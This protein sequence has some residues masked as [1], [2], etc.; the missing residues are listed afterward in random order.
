MKLR[1]WA[2]SAAILSMVCMAGQVQAAE[3]DTAEV[4]A[5]I[6]TAQKRE[7]NLQ[8]VPIVVNVVS[9][10]QLQ[11]AGVRDVKDLQVLTPGLS[12]TSSTGGAQ[13][14]IRIRG[15]GTIGDNPGLESSVGTVI[16]GV[17][18]ARSGVAFG[19]L[20][21]LERIEVLK[22]PQGT[23]FGKNTSAGV[24][25]VI[26]KA[27]E[28]D[29][30]ANAELTYGNHD[31][32]GASA[33]VTGPIGE[34]VAGRL[35][36]ALRKRDGFYDVKN[37]AGP[38]TQ[39]DNDDQDVF[40]VR[41]QLLWLPTDTLT[42]RGMVDY[43]ERNEHCCLNVTTLVGATGAIIDALA[44]DEGTLRPAD[45]FRRL[46]YANRESSQTIKDKG[47]SLQADWEINPDITLTS[48]T[49]WRDWSNRQAN[50][51]DFSSADIWYRPDDG[52]TYGKFETFS[53]EVRLAGR[54]GPIDWMVGGYYSDEQLDTSAF[55]PFGTSYET[56]FG[57]LL[58]G[59]TNPATV[60][61]LTGL[62]F[63]TNFVVGQGAYDRFDH[64]TKGGAIFTNNTWHVTDAL[65]LTVG[66]RYTDET[67]KVSGQYRNTA[68]GLACAAAIARPIPAAAR[69]AICAPGADPAFNNVDTRQKRGEDRLGGTAKASYRF[70]PQLMTYVSYANSHKSGGFNLDRARLGAGVINVDTS[71]AAETVESYEAGFKSNLFEN[72]LILNAAAFDQTFENFQLNTFTGISFVVA[73]IPKV[74]SKGVDLD[75]VWRTPVKG[76]TATGGVTYAVTQFGNFV[77]GAG[78]GPRLPTS[79]L[80]YAPLWSASWSAA[81]ETELSA[82]LRLRA[83]LSGRY[84]S[85]YNT[86]SNLDPLKNQ[87]QLTLWNGRVGLGSADERWTVEVFAQNL[88]NEKYYQVVVDQP[89]QSGT[90]AAFLGAPR[91]WGVALRSKF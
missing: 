69:A 41:G 33:S 7:Q 19:D 39:K 91:T 13:T 21:E 81:Y 59:G 66:L 2:P 42:L 51:I 14:S 50:D 84:T 62:P 12:V 40:T 9:G 73:S 25:N 30:G 24:I 85:P 87:K 76:L 23:V 28:F 31:Q 79:R 78:V 10:Q 16:D 72:R 22:G 34:T 4:E 43:T 68:P 82:A 49:A 36:V 6:V 1:K 80:S 47:V 58:S 46:A 67:K 90:Y 8:D 38:S 89:L 27:P 61:A 45:P 60:S 65:E 74:T 26:T 77:P 54:S 52:K 17:Y 56:Y 35:F 55:T 48:I 11:D 71:F 37:G 20:G 3:A 86:G 32:R 63:G 29:F 70:N 44:A 5:V 64:S 53:Q 83:S 75:A 15:V 18:R 88:T 57:L